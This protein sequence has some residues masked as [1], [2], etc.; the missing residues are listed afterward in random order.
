MCLCVFHAGEEREREMVSGHI[1][2]SLDIFITE[3]RRRIQTRCKS[4]TVP[5]HHTHTHTHTHT[6]WLIPIDGKRRQREKHEAAYLF[7]SF[8]SLP[9]SLSLSF[10]L[11]LSLTHSL[12]LSCYLSFSSILC[13]F[14]LSL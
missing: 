1:T 5:L 7:N 12:S 13:P 2:K 4:C 11:S 6:H 10:S 3:E 8:L 9:C 14:S